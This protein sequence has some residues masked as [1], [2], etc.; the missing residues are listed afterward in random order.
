MKYQIRHDTTYE[1]L[2]LVSMSHNLVHLEARG[3]ARQT[4]LSSSLTIEPAPA[5][6]VSRDDYFGNPV[7]AFTIQEPHR[8]LCVRSENVVHVHPEAAP[9]PSRTV[10]WEDAIR[11]LR[12]GRDPETLDAYQYAFDSPYI[13]VEP[14]LAAYA[15]PSFPAGRPVL[16][17]A[18]D[19]THRIHTDFR[20]DPTATTT[21]TPLRRVMELRRG[22]CQDFAHLQIGC[23]RSLGLAA[24]YVSGYLLTN[25]PPGRPRLGG[26]DA[27]HAWLSVYCPGHGW[28]DLDPTNNQVPHDNHILVAWGRDYEDVSPV[29]GVVLGGG[30]HFVAVA[31]D[32]VKLEETAPPAARA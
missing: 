13:Q 32:V 24:R 3:C 12:L 22:V 16:E 4:R 15:A 31:V 29:N 7:T 19:L 10:P 18:L 5:V 27:S 21:A 30:R 8:R 23:L 17:A 26:A 2:D 6:G 25:P 20:Y 14:G 1:Y 9:G 28:V 11:A